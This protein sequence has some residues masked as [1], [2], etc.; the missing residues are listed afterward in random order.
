M[1]STDYNYSTKYC[2][3]CV[4]ADVDCNATPCNEC[5]G[6]DLFEERIDIQE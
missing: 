2:G 4:N 1:K 6:L 5:C 3:D